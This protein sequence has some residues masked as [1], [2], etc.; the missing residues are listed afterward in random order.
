MDDSVADQ[1][2][3]ID[4]F[5]RAVKRLCDKYNMSNNVLIEGAAS[6]LSRALEL[7]LTNKMFLFGTFD[8]GTITMADTSGF[9]GI[10]T[11]PDW[12]LVDADRAHA[13]GL[14]VMLWSPDNEGENKEALRLKADIIQSD[15]PISILKLLER[16]NYD[17]ILP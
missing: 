7:G 4:Q 2:L 14:R 12:M 3:Y 1:A 8:E 10:S 9:Y 17:Y 6:H 15:D 13:K 16:Y 5:F 11:S